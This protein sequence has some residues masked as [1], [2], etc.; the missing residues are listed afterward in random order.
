MSNI[1]TEQKPFIRI[2][3]NENIDI[4]DYNITFSNDVHYPTMSL[5]FNHFNH[6]T[7]NK[8]YDAIDKFKNKNKVYL[9]TQDFEP[10]IT[11]DETIE[12]QKVSINL[13]ATE[14]IKTF[15]TNFPDIIGSG[16]YKFFEIN[17]YFNLITK[18]KSLNVVNLS[19]SDCSMFQC[20]SFIRM[21]NKNTD[22]YY[23]FNDNQNILKNY[24]NKQIEITE[25][26]KS[27][28]ADLIIC[29]TEFIVSN[30]HVQE[31]QMYEILINNINNIIDIQKKDGSLVLKIN[32]TYTSTTIKLI[33]FLKQFYETSYICKPLTSD[34]VSS[35][36]YL[37]CLNFNKTKKLTTSEKEY[38]KI[39]GKLKNKEFNIYDIMTNCVIP[40][41][42]IDFYVNLNI[43]LAILQ[44]KSINKLLIYVDNNN[45]N[46]SEY[47]AYY[48]NQITSAIYFN[49][50]FFNDNY[51]KIHKKLNEIIE[52]QV[53]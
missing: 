32:E 5:G 4:D 45:Y 9:V 42:I 23:S 20:L 41:K 33:E 44:Y 18:S 37:I 3:T 36:K 53:E 34:A 29:D 30:E 35:E 14:Y 8:Y 51:E 40:D 16:F 43:D 11:F 50:I 28:S 21:Q 1:F 22:K 19:N 52:F 10:N 38:S 2:L 27:N 48:N 17:A 24:L 39:I 26:F 15:D 13:G 25:Q 7:I 6:K 46:G 12:S 47:N 31:Q 49:G